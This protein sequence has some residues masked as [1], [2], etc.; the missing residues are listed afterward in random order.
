M[1]I[2]LILPCGG[3]DLCQCLSYLTFF[4]RFH[5]FL[6]LNIITKSESSPL[7]MLLRLGFRYSKYTQHKKAQYFQYLAATHQV[8]GP[9]TA[10]H[11]HKRT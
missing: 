5:P 4:F 6:Q 9:S 7:S 8:S 11:A 3:R 2:H 1:Y 10:T